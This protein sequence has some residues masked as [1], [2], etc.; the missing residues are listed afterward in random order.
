MDALLSADPNAAEGVTVAMGLE[1]ACVAP[2]PD[3]DMTVLG[4]EHVVNLVS[5]GKHYNALGSFL[6]WPTIKQLRKRGDAKPASIR[7]YREAVTS[8][9]E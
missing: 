7:K 2:P 9:V 8:D 6:H 3:E 1:E 4:T 5:I